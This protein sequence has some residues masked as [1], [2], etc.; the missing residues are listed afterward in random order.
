MRTSKG[1]RCHMLK[2]R[3]EGDW[4]LR[5]AAADEDAGIVRSKRQQGE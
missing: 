2:V 5:A 3:R 4:D 1:N